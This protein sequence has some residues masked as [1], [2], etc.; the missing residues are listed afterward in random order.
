VPFTLY[1]FGSFMKSA[2]FQYYMGV[3]ENACG[4]EKAA[5]KR[6]SKLSRSSERID[7]VDY[8]YPYL[9]AKSLGDSDARPKIDAALQAL[10]KTAS[11]GSRPAVAFSQGALLIAA[12]KRDE[13]DALLQKSLQSG[14]PFVQYMSLAAMADASRKR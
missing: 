1:G 4:D 11:D 8:I 7:S 10:I 13:G 9:A 2:H 5:K 14:D 3:V 12:G 6:W